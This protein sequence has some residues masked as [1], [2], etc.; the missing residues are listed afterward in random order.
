MCESPTVAP[1][2]EGREHSLSYLV[3][4]SHDGPSDRAFLSVYDAARLPDGPVARAWFDR[5]VPIT[6]HGMF[7]PA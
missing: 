2:F 3:A 5:Q 6:F 7:A 1:G 4:R